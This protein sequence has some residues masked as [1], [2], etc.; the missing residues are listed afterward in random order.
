MFFFQKKKLIK[1]KSTPCERKNLLVCKLLVIIFLRK[2][3]HQILFIY[4][5]PHKLASILYIYIY[6]VEMVPCAL[7][8][9]LL[10]TNRRFHCKL[11]S[12]KEIRMLL[13]FLS[14]DAWINDCPPPLRCKEH[15]MSLTTGI[16]TFSNEHMSSAILKF[17]S[18]KKYF[19]KIPSV[20]V[21]S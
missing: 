14:T 13:D 11:L 2:V 6:M 17:P 4:F 20:K 7:C 16:S 12:F 9:V 18:E 15:L 8:S 1:Y 10:Y 5:V 19:L 3:T 21:P